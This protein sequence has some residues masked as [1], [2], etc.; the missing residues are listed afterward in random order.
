[1][2][3]C[4]GGPGIG[5]HCPAPSDPVLDAG[6]CALQSV[7]RLAWCRAPLSAGG[8]VRQRRDCGRGRQRGHDARARDTPCLRRRHTGGDCGGGR[9][10]HTAGKKRADFAAS[11]WLVGRFAGAASKARTPHMAGGG[12]LACG[13]SR[14]AGNRAALL[15][16]TSTARTSRRGRAL[17]PLDT[18]RV[19]AHG[20]SRRALARIPHRRRG[21][22]SLA[23]SAAGNCARRLREGAGQLE[24]RLP[25]WVE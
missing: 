22:R 8:G 6:V 20:A 25:G 12:F 5:A 10:G 23:A 2:P 16:R 24:E 7:R 11:A 13:E 21:P 18:A 1:M 3:V 17:P 14:P 19:I 15:H 9:G 4:G